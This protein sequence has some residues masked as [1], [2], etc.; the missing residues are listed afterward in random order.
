MKSSIVF[1]SISLFCLIA[2]G[3]L[4]AATYYKALDKEGNVHITDNPNDPNLNYSPFI[5]QESIYEKYEKRERFRKNVVK[6]IGLDPFL[7]NPYYEARKAVRGVIN[8]PDGETEYKMLLPSY[9]MRW[10][11]VGMS[12]EN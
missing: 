6:D 3:Y 9:I 4:N 12:S 8:T 10:Q 5:P 1:V 11:Q 7:W 2:C